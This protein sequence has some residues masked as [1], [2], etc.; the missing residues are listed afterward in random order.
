M[1]RPNKNLKG[2]KSRQKTGKRKRIVSRNSSSEKKQWNNTRPK[3]MK[4]LKS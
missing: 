1:H 4:D 2:G 3:R